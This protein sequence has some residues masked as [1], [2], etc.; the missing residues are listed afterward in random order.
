MAELCFVQ[1]GVSFINE[2]Q[3]ETNEGPICSAVYRFGS[4]PGV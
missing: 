2:R 1:K 4:M 3:K